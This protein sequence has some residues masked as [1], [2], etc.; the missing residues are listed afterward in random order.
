MLP[1]KIRQD[2]VAM[3]QQILKATRGTSPM[4]FANRNDGEQSNEDPSVLIIPQ[5]L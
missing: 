2:F 3:A 1:S 4:N 5:F